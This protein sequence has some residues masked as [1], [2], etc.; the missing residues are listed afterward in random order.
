MLPGFYPNFHDNKI[1]S[2]QNYIVFVIIMLNFLRKYLIVR[3][4]EKKCS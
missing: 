2:S 3:R 4:D 1:I